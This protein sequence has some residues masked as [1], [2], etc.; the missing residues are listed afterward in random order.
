MPRSAESSERAASRYLMQP[1]IREEPGQ[2]PGFSRVDIG[3]RTESR[4]GLPSGAGASRPW[5]YL[6]TCNCAPRAVTWRLS[7][8]S[9]RCRSCSAP[10]EARALSLIG[11]RFAGGSCSQGVDAQTGQGNAS[12]QER[13]RCETLYIKMSIRD[14]HVL[15]APDL[16]IEAV[17]HL[18]GA[19]GQCPV[20]LRRVLDG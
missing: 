19:L 5:R 8:P 17:N 3:A 9:S 6:R 15:F 20:P 7:C 2:E 14:P 12:V 1:C 4:P 11:A 16:V 13:D 10:S 18:R